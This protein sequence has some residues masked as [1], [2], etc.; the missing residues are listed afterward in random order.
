[1]YFIYYLFRFLIPYCYPVINVNGGSDSLP[2]AYIYTHLCA[3]C[4]FKHTLRTLALTDEYAFVEACVC[5]PCVCVYLWLVFASHKI[6]TPWLSVS[7]WKC[8]VKWA[9]RPFKFVSFFP[10][11][12]YFRFSAWTVSAVTFTDNL[13]NLT[14]IFCHLAF[15]I[16]TFYVANTIFGRH[17]RCRAHAVPQLSQWLRNCSKN[18][19]KF[20]F[21]LIINQK[22]NRK[23][24]Q[25]AL[26]NWKKVCEL[27]FCLK[28]KVKTKRKKL[29]KIIRLQKC[30]LPCSDNY[31][32]YITVTP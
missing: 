22:D 32:K 1:M 19:I 4:D 5:V 9:F 29:W 18:A 3:P 8:A 12:F 31:K 30:I 11:Y 14:Q 28:T 10:R 13:W 26:L 24:E 27:N 21:I 20:I 7:V 16:C 15:A 23:N 6:Y 2:E 17:S 25:K